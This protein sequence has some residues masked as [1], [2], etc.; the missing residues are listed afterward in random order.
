M[1]YAIEDIIQ[2]QREKLEREPAQNIYINRKD[3][4][5]LLDAAAGKKDA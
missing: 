1:M 4:T 5:R 2:Y 3:L